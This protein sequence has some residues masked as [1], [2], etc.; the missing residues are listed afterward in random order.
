M[1]LKKWPKAALNGILCLSLPLGQILFSSCF[2]ILQ[3]L[4][5]SF[6]L[7][8]QNGDLLAFISEGHCRKSLVL[9]CSSLGD[10][11]G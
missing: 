7:R 4:E 11:F 6:L 1:F 8:F 9:E 3:E 5:R 2:Y 10:L